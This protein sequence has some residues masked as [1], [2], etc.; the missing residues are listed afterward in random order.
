MDAAT[1]RELDDLRA[2][3]ARLDRRRR[4]P[5]RPVS[6]ALVTLLVALLPLSL[7]AAN[8]FGDLNAGSPHNGNIDLIYNAGITR[9]CDPDA[10]YCPNGLVTREEMASFLARTA[11][12]G[13]NPPVV[14]AKTAQSITKGAARVVWQSFTGT[15]NTSNPSAVSCPA[16]TT[17]IGG[18][19]K[20]DGQSWVQSFPVGATINGAS[21]DAGIATGWGAFFYNTGTTLTVYAVCLSMT[22]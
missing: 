14:N 16:G 13:A 17:A 15:A 11:G 6:L 21:G 4:F 9:G 18:G 22:P 7:L 3:V 10:A 8:P 5:R 19:A 12:L 1:R 20:T 2:R